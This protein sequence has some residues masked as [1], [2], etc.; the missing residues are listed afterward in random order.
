MIVT[1]LVKRYENQSS[2]LVSNFLCD[3]AKYFLVI[4]GN[5]RKKIFFKLENCGNRNL[6]QTSRLY[7]RLEKR[8][9][10]CI[11]VR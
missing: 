3:K 8:R 6:I 4:D 2:G 1:A 10:S 5:C 9:K 11:Y 7:E